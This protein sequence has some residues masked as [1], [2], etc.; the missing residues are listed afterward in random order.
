M[1]KMLIFSQ[2]LWAAGRLDDLEQFWERD[3]RATSDLRTAMT[4]RISQRSL[5]DARVVMEEKVH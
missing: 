1:C 4:L 2:L 3:V 5:Q